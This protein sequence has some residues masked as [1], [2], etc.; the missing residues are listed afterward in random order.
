M[1]GIE[2]GKKTIEIPGRKASNIA[3]NNHL[4]ETKKGRFIMIPRNPITKKKPPTIPHIIG[5]IMKYI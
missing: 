3:N 2:L 1:K 4:L 5:I